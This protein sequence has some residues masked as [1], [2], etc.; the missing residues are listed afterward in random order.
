MLNKEHYGII[1]VK[2][3]QYIVHSTNVYE[4]KPHTRGLERQESEASDFKD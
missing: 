1:W 2:N 4:A 3:I